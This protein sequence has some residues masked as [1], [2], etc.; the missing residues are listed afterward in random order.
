VGHQVY[1]KG[2]IQERT[3]ESWLLPPLRETLRPRSHYKN[4]LPPVEGGSKIGAELKSSLYVRLD[5]F[6]RLE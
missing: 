2:Y 6:T 4:L 1:Q 5:L 3:Q